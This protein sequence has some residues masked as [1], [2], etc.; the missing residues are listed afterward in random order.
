MKVSAV[1]IVKNMEETLANCLASLD[2]C[3]EIICYDTG[4]TDNTLTIAQSF[5]NVRTIQGDFHGF[6]KSKQIAVSH[7]KNDWIFSIDGDESVDSDLK[8]AI[9]NFAFDTPHH[10]GQ[11][12]RD[13]YFYGKAITV[14]GWGRDKLIRLFNRTVYQF[15]D[16]KVHESIAL[17][18]QAIIIPLNGK[19]VHDAV[20]DVGQFLRKIDH[21]SA[22]GAQ[23]IKPKPFIMIVAKTVFAFIRSYFL[24]LGFCAGWRGFTIA[25]CQAIGTYFKYLRARLK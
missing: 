25:F 16:R 20:R 2:F 3:D 9:L 15:N 5:A 18:S 11:I 6:G 14:G 7:A 1:L 23:H 12:T 13:N 24:Q 22:L 21:Y 10:V 19:L 4:S 8:N 17:D